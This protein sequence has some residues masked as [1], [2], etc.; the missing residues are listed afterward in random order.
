MS[1]ADRRETLYRLHAW[2][3][4]YGFALAALTVATL[5]RY[6]LDV[7][8]GFS[9]PFILFYPTIMLVALLGGVGPG[10]M[11]TVLSAGLAA[12]FFLAP[13]NSF[14][15]RHP[16]DIVGLMLFLVIGAAIS[17]M[18]DLFRR[19]T[20]RLQEFEKA[21]EGLEEMMVVV[22]RD[23]QGKAGCVLP[24]QD[25]AIRNTIHALVTG[26]ARPFRLT[27]SDPRAWRGRPGG[28]R[29]AGHHRP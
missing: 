19:R 3:R 28:M 22:D 17:G 15:V 13:F 26:Q 20:K 16:H 18:S 24:G 9:Q 21:V 23:D 14:T 2:P 5:V 10:L 12:Y 8:L 29:V 7:A 27:L 1:S 4:R 6:G 11:A 25:R